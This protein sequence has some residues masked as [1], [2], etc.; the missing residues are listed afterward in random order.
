MCDIRCV[1]LDSSEPAIRF[2]L[3][4]GLLDG[5]IAR[6]FEVEGALPTEE[7][8][9]WFRSCNLLICTGAIGYVSDRTLDIVLQDLGK[10]HPS[11]FGPCAVFTILRMFD[12]EPVEAVFEKHGFAMSAVPG[13]RLPQR[14]FEDAR[15]REQVLTLLHERGI[16]TGSWEEQGRHYADL[17]VAARPEHSQE[18]LDCACA[19]SAEY[20]D[21]SMLA[22]YIRR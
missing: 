4:S 3:G 6:N 10:D 2:G 22:G 13:A 16:D 7:D 9:S 1:G 12:T 20:A 14:K 8:R 17:Y 19:T 18:L 11:D 15:E 21:D 5:G